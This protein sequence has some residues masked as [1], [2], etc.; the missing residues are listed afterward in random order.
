MPFK[1]H[2]EKGRES[3][4]VNVP[5][6]SALGSAISAKEDSFDKKDEESPQPKE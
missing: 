6:T 4:T 2:G 5:G 3:I 1:K